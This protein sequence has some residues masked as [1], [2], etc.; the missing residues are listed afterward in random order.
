MLALY[1]AGRQAEALA[2]YAD[3]R[4]HPRRRA[5]ARAGPRAAPAPA[6]RAAPRAGAGAP[7]RPGRRRGGAARAAARAVAGR[8]RGRLL[9]AGAAAA[10][11]LTRGDETRPRARARSPAGSCRDRRGDRRAI[12]RRIA[13]GRTPGALA[14]TGDGRL[15]AVDADARTLL[16][17]G[18]GHRRRSRRSPPAGRRPSVAGGAGR[19]GGRRRAGGGRAVRRAGDDGRATA[20]GRHAHGPRHRRAAAPGRAGEQ[21]GREPAR[22]LGARRL[23]RRAVRRRRADRPGDGG[24]DRSHAA[25]GRVRRG[26]RG[27]RRLGAAAGRR[28]ARARRG[29]GARA[30]PDPPADGRPGAHRGL[31]GRGLGHRAA[32][33]SLFRIPASPDGRPIAAL[34][35]GAGAAE[36]AAGPGRRVGG[37]PG[38]GHARRGRRARRRASSGPSA[39][40]ACRGR[41]RWR[42]GRS[43]S[44]WPAGGRPPAPGASPA[45]AP[46]RPRCASPPSRAPGTAPTS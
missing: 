34:D 30:P 40:A 28:R 13:A 19:L 33:R 14:R 32:R 36:V 6:G 41:W 35:V 25:R 31:R 26:G 8:P 17:R 27:R 23:G 39:S 9:V 15:W 18:P 22:R 24:R 46:C 37:E 16:A 45:S 4:R 11:A 42:A 38:R 21:H 44:R 7:P 12:V 29:H 20:R 10:L 5:R 43:G 1:R 3:A 2:A